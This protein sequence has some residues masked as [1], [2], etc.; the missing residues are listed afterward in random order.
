MCCTSLR[1]WEFA[2]QVGGTYVGTT[3][4]LINFSIYLFI[5]KNSMCGSS[6]ILR[7]Y[8]YVST[9]ISWIRLQ[10]RRSTPYGIEQTA[11][12]L[13]VTIQ[14]SQPSMMCNDRFFRAAV[15][16]FH[17]LRKRLI[18]KKTIPIVRL[19]SGKSAVQHLLPI[20]FRQVPLPILKTFK[21]LKLHV[22]PQAS[23]IQWVYGNE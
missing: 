13:Y 3:R 18:K 9:A 8:K 5:L 22:H 19:R 11:L 20:R 17:L 12:L 2:L 16:I 21:N 14:Y 1:Y 10:T 4:S 7:N 6:F 15:I 23:Y